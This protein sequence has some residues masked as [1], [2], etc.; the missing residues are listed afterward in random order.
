MLH[1]RLNLNP[2]PA[3][4][5]RVTRWGAFYGKRHQAFREEAL[6]LLEN[7]REQGNLPKNLLSGRLQVWVFIQVKKPKT[8]KLDIPRGDIDNYLKLILDCCTG[9]V[10]EDDIH[11]EEVCGY[12]CFATDTGSIDLWVKERNDET[13]RPIQENIQPTHT[14]GFGSD[15]YE[16]TGF[17]L[18]PRGFVTIPNLPPCCENI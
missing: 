5:P 15:T 3:S 8:S 18:C 16:G 2:V 9:F 6:A 11:I 10:W 17:Y 14:E 13:I 1:L 4:R 12:K 7:M